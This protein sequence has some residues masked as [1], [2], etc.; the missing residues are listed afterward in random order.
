MKRWIPI[1]N[2]D[3]TTTYALEAGNGVLVR[4]TLWIPCTD[5]VAAVALCFIPNASISNEA[6]IIDKGSFGPTW[7]KP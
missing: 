6:K 7:G 5:Q 3:D 1:I 4:E 2:S